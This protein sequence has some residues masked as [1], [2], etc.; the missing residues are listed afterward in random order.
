MSA[1]SLGG[2]SR[3]HSEFDRAWLVQS[4]W[5]RLKLHL[6]YNITRFISLS[7]FCSY[8]VC[9]SPVVTKLTVGTNGPQVDSSI[10]PFWRAWDDASL[11]YTAYSRAGN[12]SMGHG[13]WVM[14]QMGHKHQ[15]GHMGHGS[16][17]VDPWPISFLTL[18]LSLYIVAMIIYRVSLWCMCNCACD[19]W[20]SKFTFTFKFMLVW[21]PRGIGY[22][23]GT[24]VINYPGNFLLLDGYP[25]SEYLM[26]RMYLIGFSELV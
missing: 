2:G 14:G 9:P 25:G 3:S 4:A 8:K 7:A 16:L 1:A 19:W 20:S 24:R 10:W 17:G 26:C 12:G 21:L 23:S 18:W 22:P 15:M 5:R 6:L 11:S 13:S